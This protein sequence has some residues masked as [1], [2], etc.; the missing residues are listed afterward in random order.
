MNEATKRTIVKEIDAILYEEH[1]VLDHGFIRVVDYMGSDS[2]IVQAARVSYGKGT[3]QTSQDEALIKYLMRHHHTTPFEMCEIKFHVKLPIFVARQ[4][5]RHRTANVNEYSARYSILDNEFYTPKPEQVAKQSDN[6]KQGSGE[7]FD[8]DTSKEIID[9]LTNDSNLVYSHYEKFIGQGLAREIA[10]TNL[11]LNYYTQFYWKID[12]HNLLHFLKLR[13]DKHS[14]Y[15]I[16]VYAEVMLDIIKKW[17][18]LAYNAFVEYCLESACISRT[19][20]EIIR[21][22]I[23]G[24]NVT[25]EESNIGKREWGELMSI[26]DKQSINSSLL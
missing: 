1:K 15:E 25:R 2:A 18:P 6:N 12:L 9:S 4:W 7:A 14:Q 10:R 22:L 5:I 26:L 17:V 13:A 23:K 24:E 19:G 8:P 3:K 11:M 16:R 20:L 21:K